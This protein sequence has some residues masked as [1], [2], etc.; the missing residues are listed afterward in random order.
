[1]L[2]WAH[3]LSFSA[4]AILIADIGHVAA[5]KQIAKESNSE[6]HIKHY[7][8]LTPSLEMILVTLA[9]HSYIN[10]PTTPSVKALR[11]M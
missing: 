6:P 7:S 8:V 4:Y 2:L 11:E 5:T 3:R 10:P 1:M 9:G